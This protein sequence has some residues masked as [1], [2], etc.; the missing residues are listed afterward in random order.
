MQETKY[1]RAQGGWSATLKLR[2]LLE[3]NSQLTGCSSSANPSDHRKRKC[4]ISAWSREIYAA[5]IISRH[6]PESCCQSDTQLITASYD[7]AVWTC[8]LT[9][10]SFQQ[11]AVSSPK[12]LPV[13]RQLT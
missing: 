11:R 1:R 5:K 4:I 2:L 8:E 6:A 12:S 9:D 3:P 10:N 13:G 7:F